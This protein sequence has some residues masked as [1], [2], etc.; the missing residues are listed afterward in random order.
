MKF[1]DLAMN[2]NNFMINLPQ[3]LLQKGINLQSYLSVDV[4]WW[5][6]NEAL[7]IVRIAKKTGLGISLCD[8]VEKVKE[9]YFYNYECLKVAKNG[10]ETWDDYVIRSSSETKKFIENFQDKNVLFAFSF[11]ERHP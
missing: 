10:N 3:Q 1:P 9:D 5:E 7:E 4:L 2:F 8:V 11:S 6:K